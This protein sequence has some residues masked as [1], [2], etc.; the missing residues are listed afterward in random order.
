ME[1]GGHAEEHGVLN[2]LELGHI[3]VALHATKAT[4]HSGLDLKRKVLGNK[5]SLRQSVFEVGAVVLLCDDSLRLNPVPL[6]V[7]RDLYPIAGPREIDDAECVQ[8]NDI[9]QGTFPLKKAKKAVE[10]HTN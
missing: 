5:F 9:G 4:E 1:Q 3:P 6:D 8:V 10:M 2:L 7:D